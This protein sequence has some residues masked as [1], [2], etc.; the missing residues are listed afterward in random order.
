MPACGSTLAES[1]VGP[2][3]AAV[4]EAQLL[5]QWP[6]AWS[7]WLGFNWN[8]QFSTSNVGPHP[9]AAGNLYVILYW[10]A[11]PHKHASRRCFFRGWRF[12]YNTRKRALSKKEVLNSSEPSLFPIVLALKQLSKAKTSV[13]CPFSVIKSR[14]N[15]HQSILQPWIGLEM[16][17]CK[18]ILSSFLWNCQKVYPYEEIFLFFTLILTFSCCSLSMAN[19]GDEVIYQIC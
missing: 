11:C 2:G 1:V 16:S 4:C 3:L 6:G 13:L 18:F 8:T 9:H 15:T 5:R 19:I 10:T 7:A 14:R 17:L 12:K